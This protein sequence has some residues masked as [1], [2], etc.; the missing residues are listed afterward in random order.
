MTAIVESNVTRK[1]V[2]AYDILTKLKGISEP[3]VGVYRLTMKANSDNFRC[4]AIYDIMDTLKDNGVM[5]IINEPTIHSS[6]YN[7]YNV[8]K[9]L[10]QFAKRCDLIITNRIEDALKP[11]MDKVYTRDIFGD[12]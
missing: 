8:M 9:D 6:E 3:V 12:N 2:I 7:G 4:S 5:V 11:Y 1:S 10:E